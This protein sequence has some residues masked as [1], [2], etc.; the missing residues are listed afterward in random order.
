MRHFNE[1]FRK[2]VTSDNIKTPP[3]NQGFKLSFEDTFWEK[4]QREG[5]SQIDSPAF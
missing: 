4:L 1:I 5:G 2:Y 3:K